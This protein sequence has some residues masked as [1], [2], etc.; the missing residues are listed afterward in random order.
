MFPTRRFIWS[1]K[2][3]VLV[4]KGKWVEKVYFKVKEKILLHSITIFLLQICF[5]VFY[6]ITLCLLKV[7]IRREN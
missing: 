3:C 7:F 6:F 1:G 4:L 5:R 2:E